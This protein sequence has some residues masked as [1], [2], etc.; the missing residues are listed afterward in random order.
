MKS[1]EDL[2]DLISTSRNFK[3]KSVNITFS[4][5]ERQ[6]MHPI[7]GVPQ[8]YHDQLNIIARYLQDIK[9]DIQLQCNTNGSDRILSRVNKLTRRKLKEADDWLDWNE[10]E[11]QQLDMYEKKTHL[12]PLMNYHQ[13]QIY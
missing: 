5:V 9:Q 6:A 11:H 4:T 10:A 1:I 2:V 12:P 8:L 3:E 13:E 7:Y